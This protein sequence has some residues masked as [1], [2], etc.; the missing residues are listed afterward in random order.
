MAAGAVR[1]GVGD[2]GRLD[3]TGV[4]GR[5]DLEIVRARPGV[6]VQASVHWTQ[7]AYPIRSAH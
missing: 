6:A 7:V 3:V 5:A 1:G 4:V 2:L